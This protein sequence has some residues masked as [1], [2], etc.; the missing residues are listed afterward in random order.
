MVSLSTIILIGG[1]ALFLLAGGGKFISPAISK[2]KI[3]LTS[4][5]DLL[6]DAAASIKSK[7]ESVN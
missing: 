3:A 5:K 7:S 1:A 6:G 2:T 4:G